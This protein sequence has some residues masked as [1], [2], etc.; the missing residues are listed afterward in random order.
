MCALSYV[1]SIYVRLLLKLQSERNQKESPSD[2]E[3]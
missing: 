1:N 2:D 3:L